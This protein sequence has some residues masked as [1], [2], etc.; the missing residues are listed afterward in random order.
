[1][2]SH[3]YHVT[4]PTFRAS[5]LLSVGHSLLFGLVFTLTIFDNPMSI[6]C[7]VNDNFIT[8]ESSN[9]FDGQAL[10]FWNPNENDDSRDDTKSTI[11]NCVCRKSVDFP[12]IIE[13]LLGLA[14]I[15]AE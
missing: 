7:Q 3:L 10:C 15:V 2:D 4:D 11:K 12:K 9:F 1:M 13:L 8:K 6:S 5:R 14:E